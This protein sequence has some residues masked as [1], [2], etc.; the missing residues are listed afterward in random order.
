MQKDGYLKHWFGKEDRKVTNSF[1]CCVFEPVCACAY[2][3]ACGW[4]ISLGDNLPSQD[5]LVI[6]VFS[7][8]NYTDT[9]GNKG[10]YLKFT[11]SGYSIE[12]FEHEPHPFVLPN[13]Q[14][15]IAFTL[16]FIAEHGAPYDPFTQLDCKTLAPMSICISPLV[17]S[18]E[19]VCANGRDDGGGGRGRGRRR[20]EVDQEKA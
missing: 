11:G 16:P 17:P 2:A 14:D 15:G 19:G 7:A 1:M 4:Q 9:H 3:C 13:F 5:P 8:P 18:V 20:A 12:T 6:T 10:A